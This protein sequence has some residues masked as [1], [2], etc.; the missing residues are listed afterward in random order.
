MSVG[1]V[2]GEEMSGWTHVKV[3][4]RWRRNR[5]PDKGCIQEALPTAE[6]QL[7]L[8]DKLVSSC[9]YPDAKVITKQK[10][11]CTPQQE[12]NTSI[13]ISFALFT[14]DTYTCLSA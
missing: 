8:L 11:G 4:Q 1:A 13:N 6:M 9:H 5:T 10:T 3:F 14:K 2:Y 7:R 12:T